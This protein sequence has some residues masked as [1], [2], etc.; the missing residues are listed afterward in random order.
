MQILVVAIHVIV[1]FALIM[2]VLLQTGKGADIGAAFGGGSSQTLFGSSG[3]GNFLTKATTVA[4][5]VF[6]LTSLTLAYLSSQKH[7]SSVMKSVPAKEE[8][9]AAPVGGAEGLPALPPSTGGVIPK[10]PVP[11]AAV[12]SVP[13]NMPAPSSGAVPGSLPQG[14]KVEAKTTANAAI[15]ATGGAQPVKVTVPAT[16]GATAQPVK[17]N[18]PVSAPQAA[19]AAP[20]ASP[21]PATE[22]PSA[23]DAAK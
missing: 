13:V 4:A 10:V 2:I 23:P 3:A 14:V 9:P 8:A 15:P 20:T 16:G 6:M 22:A 11:G 18:V 21:Q 1:C 5:I 17:V 19:P 7:Q 12:P